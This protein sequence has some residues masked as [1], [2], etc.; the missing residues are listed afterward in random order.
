MINCNIFSLHYKFINIKSN[1]TFFILVSQLFLIVKTQLFAKNKKNLNY[2]TI[3]YWIKIHKFSRNN[4][5]SNDLR[6]F[7]NVYFLRITNFIF[8]F[9]SFRP[10]LLIISQSLFDKIYIDY[11]YYIHIS[12]H[13]FNIGNKRDKL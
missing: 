9:I 7:N 1:L 5:F 3:N 4:K 8:I 13:L 11:G 10:I 2:I 6:N 12:N